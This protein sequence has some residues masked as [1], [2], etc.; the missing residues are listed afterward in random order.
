MHELTGP[1]GG[2]LLVYPNNVEPGVQQQHRAEVDGGVAWLARLGAGSTTPDYNLTLPGI[3]LKIYFVLALDAAIFAVTTSTSTWSTPCAVMLDA[4][5]GATVWNNTLTGDHAQFMALKAWSV[6]GAPGSELLIQA[7][8]SNA[9]AYDLKSGAEIWTTN[10][11]NDFISDGLTVAGDTVLALKDGGDGNSNTLVA[12]STK[13]GSL[14]WQYPTAV[15]LA[16]MGAVE[17]FLWDYQCSLP[18][19][20]N[21]GISNSGGTSVC[22][23]GFSCQHTGNGGRDVDCPATLMPPGYPVCGKAESTCNLAL[24]AHTGAIL[25]SQPISSGLPTSM[26]NGKADLFRLGDIVML[27]GK[28]GTLSGMSVS[29]GSMLWTVPCSSCA[30][31]LLAFEY[32]AP[33][34]AC[35]AELVELCAAAKSAGAAQC[36][37]CAGQNAALLHVAGCS[38]E[39]ITSWCTTTAN[40]RSAIRRADLS[41]SG[42]KTLIVAGS[43][44]STSSLPAVVVLEPTTGDVQWTVTVNISGLPDTT[45]SASFRSKSDGAHWSITPMWVEL[46]AGNENGGQSIY[47]SGRHTEERA[48]ERHVR[49]RAQ[50]PPP[51]PTTFYNY[52]TW[53]VDSN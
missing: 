50:I 38:N 9:T 27:N 43:D 41:P 15:Q 32:V 7:M 20:P 37:M 39:Q 2:L 34:G 35:D 5:S 14:A 19:P 6:V 8:Q 47:L 36:G 25:Y 42:N 49:R 48:M 45:S 30:N 4:N 17:V 46:T 11:L 31:S 16:G 13:D 23:I 51:P 1:T 18:S 21:T 29:N 28:S 22:W 10:A 12:V 24:N 3:A 33:K 26:G 53:R 52:Y 40:N 44:S